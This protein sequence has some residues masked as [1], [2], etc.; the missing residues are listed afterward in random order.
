MRGEGDTLKPQDADPREDRDT[1]RLVERFQAGDERAFDTLY[2]RYFKR[3]YNYLRVAIRDE[4]EAEDLTQQ[5]FVAM[6]EGLDRYEPR[7]GRPFRAWLFTIA[8]NK[9]AS[10]LRREHPVLT[11]PAELERH[12]DRSGAVEP[13]PEPDL[14]ALRW[15]TDSE[16]QLFLER[17]P[18]PQR[19]VLVLRYMFGLDT[20]E[21]AD[22]LGVAPG[23]IRKRQA[24]ALSFLRSRLEAIGRG[25]EAPGLMGTRAPLR[26]SAV[27][28]GRRFSLGGPGPTR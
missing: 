28:R 2:T 13:P 21:M 25:P 9:A 6:L 18:L 22:V 4:T 1:A 27:L 11:D 26:P 14:A 19:Q 16:V 7:R 8:R 23:T 20:D 12:I 24:R 10:E 17:L 15:I 3:V 5:V